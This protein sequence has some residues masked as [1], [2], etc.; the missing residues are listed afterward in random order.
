MINSDEI[1]PLLVDSLKGMT[2]PQ[3]V[4]VFY[5]LFNELGV[6][7]DNSYKTAWAKFIHQLTGKC[8]QNIRSGLNIDF[9][10]KRTHKNMRFVASFLLNCSLDLGENIK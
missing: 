5:Y 7:F 8:Q 10:S 2:V 4:L 9:F 1:N 3:L 6:N